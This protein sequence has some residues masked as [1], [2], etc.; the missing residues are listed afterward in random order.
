MSDILNQS[1]FNT[2]PIDVLYIASLLRATAAPT[3]NNHSN[4]H[5]LTLDEFICAATDEH[6]QQCR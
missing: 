4:E 3:N 6:E 5:Q 1:V 2:K